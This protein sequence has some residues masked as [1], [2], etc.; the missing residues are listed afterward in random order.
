MPYDISKVDPPSKIYIDTSFLITALIEV[1][2]EIYRHRKARSFLDK[3]ISKKTT[4]FTSLLTEIEFI[5]TCVYLALKPIVGDTVKEAVKKNPKLFKTHKEKIDRYI[6]RYKWAREK[7]AGK[8]NE[9]AIDKQV[10]KLARECA[11][12]YNL[13]FR[14]GIHLAT[15]RI[16][17]CDNVLS[18]DKDFTHVENIVFYTLTKKT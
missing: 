10:I 13:M 9:H 8:W 1:P 16:L 11:Q 2:A 6:D 3:I 12:E 5:E 7:L 18:L 4:V 17:F 15:A 14:D